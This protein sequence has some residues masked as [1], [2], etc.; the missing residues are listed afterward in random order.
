MF[1]CAVI[2]FCAAL[3]ITL[4]ASIPNGY[5]IVH[6]YPHDPDAFTQKLTYVDGLFTEWTVDL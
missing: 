5:H 3:T 1:R 6:T 2:L 4:P